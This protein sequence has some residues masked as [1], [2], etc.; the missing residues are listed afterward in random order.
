MSQCTEFFLEIRQFDS[1]TRIT[2]Q[3]SS[4]LISIPICVL[5]AT[6]NGNNA[7]SHYIGNHI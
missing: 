2:K 4:T 3:V 7:V 5:H 1:L 6:I